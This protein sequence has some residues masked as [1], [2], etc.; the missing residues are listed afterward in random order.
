LTQVKSPVIINVIKNTITILR[1]EQRLMILMRGNQT[2]IILDQGATLISW[3]AGTTHI[4]H[5]LQMMSVPTPAGMVN[6]LR[7]GSPT[8][9]PNFGPPPEEGLVHPCLKE[10]RL[11][12]HGF[13]RREM[14]SGHR[15]YSK[16]MADYI[17]EATDKTFDV[18]PWRFW[19][20]VQF[21]AT[22][23][24][25]RHYT[26]F[27]N[28]GIAGTPMPWG[29]AY[30]PYLRTPK[31]TAV[32]RIG[33]RE[34]RVSGGSYSLAEAV[35][36]APDITVELH[37]LGI[38]QMALGRLFL[39]SKAKVIIW[40]DSDQYICVEP[41]VARPEYFGTEKGVLIDPGESASVT[42]VYTFTPDW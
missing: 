10:S 19:L 42:C 2:L 36:A 28:R 3:Q 32:V 7:G 27:R 25:F 41:T 38:V 14:P 37:G 21:Q 31:G 9:T 33:D 6:K 5:P 1:K 22:E 23:H 40:T 11:Q 24:G 15:S 35:D 18:F 12:Q 17:F 29:V 4:I 34:Y 26:E 8:P 39:Q 30:H 16:A 20:V 13:L